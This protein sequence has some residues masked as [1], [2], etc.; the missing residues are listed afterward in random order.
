MLQSQLFYKSFREAPKDEESINARLL[1]RAGF[2]NK[3][4]AG[5]YTYL[6]LGL[7]VLNKIENIVREE[8]NK[9]GGHE[10]LMPALHPKDIWEITDRWNSVD[11]LFKIKN[12]SKSEYALGPTHEE[13]IYSMLTNFVKSYRDLPIHLYQIQTKFRDEP[14]AKSGLLRNREFRMKDLYSFHTSDEE[15]NNYYKIVKTAYTKIFKKLGL[16]AIFVSALGGTFS[17]ESHE[18]QVAAKAGEDAIFLCDKCQFAVNKEKIN[19]SK[20]KSKKLTCPNCGGEIKEEKTIEVGNIF[21]LKEKFAK[22]FNLTFKDKQGQS[23]LVSAGCYGLGTSRVMGTVVEVHNDNKGIIW[24]EEIAPFKYHLIN[25]AKNK[26]K[27]KEIYETLQKKNLD[28][29]YDDRQDKTI[30]EKL[31]EADL[32]GIPMRI[33][34]SDKTLLKGNVEIKKRGENEIR[35]IKIKELNRFLAA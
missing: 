3:T 6:P 4:M 35:F 24:P 25:L 30:G 2:I 20:L 8:I 17:D 32:I 22:D 7:R 19:F 29:L 31:N 28:I 11:V 13:V 14:R 27:S 12:N 16:K 9:I 21:P 23:K 18:F 1:I 15:R 10:L 5:V 33:I 26:R 34:L